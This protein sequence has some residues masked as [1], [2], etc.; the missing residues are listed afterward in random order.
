MKLMCL[1]KYTK[2]YRWAGLI[3]VLVVQYMLHL[4]VTDKPHVRIVS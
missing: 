4:C 2:S 3:P 1:F